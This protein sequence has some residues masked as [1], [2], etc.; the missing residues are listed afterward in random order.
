MNFER[1][2]DILNKTI[3]KKYNDLFKYSPLVVNLNMLNGKIKDIRLG[4]RPQQEKIEFNGY[5]MINPGVL[6]VNIDL[7]TDL[8]CEID[9]RPEDCIEMASDFLGFDGW[10]FI[11]SVIYPYVSKKYFNLF[12]FSFKDFP[13]IEI[14]VN[15]K[16]GETLFY[17]E[18]D[19][20]SLSVKKV[21]PYIWK[22]ID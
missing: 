17:D 16:Y 11:N 1:I 2:T 21:N 8:T 10:H 19:V 3:P 13:Y 20:N 4:F 15:N 14:S 5:E 7:N 18:I 6:V 9:D 22:R 12:G